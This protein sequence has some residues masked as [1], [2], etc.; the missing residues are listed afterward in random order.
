MSVAFIIEEGSLYEEEVP[1]RSCIRVHA[2][3]VDINTVT[4]CVHNGREDERK[5]KNKRGR[6]ERKGG[7]L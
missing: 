1:F 7:Y 2:I 5:G 4:I 3:Y 6:V